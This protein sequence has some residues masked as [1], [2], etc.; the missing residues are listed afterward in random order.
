MSVTIYGQVTDFNGVPI[1][2]A[3]VEIKDKRFNDLYST[4][5]DENGY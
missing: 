1:T 2:G 3:D 4:L 5:S